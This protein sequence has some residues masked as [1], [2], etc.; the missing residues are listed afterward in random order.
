MPIHVLLLPYDSA[1]WY[2]TLPHVKTEDDFRGLTDEEVEK[3]MEYFKEPHQISQEDVES[4]M[5][6]EIYTF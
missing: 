3:Y 4:D 1:S 5:G 6:F 2:H